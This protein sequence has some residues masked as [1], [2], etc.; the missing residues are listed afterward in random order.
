LLSLHNSAPKE[1][2]YL[3][4]LGLNIKYILLARVGRRTP[5]NWRAL[6]ERFLAH[7]EFSEVLGNYA[8]ASMVL[9]L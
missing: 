8:A 3:V 2:A 4:G 1:N 9:T 7:P 5:K 6:S